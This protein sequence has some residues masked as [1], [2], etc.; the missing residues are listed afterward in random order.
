MSPFEKRNQCAICLSGGSLS[1][2]KLCNGNFYLLLSFKHLLKCVFSCV[3]PKLLGNYLSG[4]PSSLFNLPTVTN[5]A[6]VH[7]RSPQ[8]DQYQSVSE[9][10]LKPG[11]WHFFGTPFSLRDEEIFWAK[12][13]NGCAEFSRDLL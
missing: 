5:A 1:I 13:G 8:E 9:I 4:S 10:S 7:R 11:Y 6:T 12:S 2:A 3:L